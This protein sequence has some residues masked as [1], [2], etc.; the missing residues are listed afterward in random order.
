MED[1]VVITTSDAGVLHASRALLLCNS[2][3]FAD[4]LVALPDNDADPE[5]EDEGE[6]AEEEGQ[7]PHFNVPETHGVFKAFLAVMSGEEEKRK[8][9]LGQLVRDEEWEQLAQAAASYNVDCVRVVVQSKIWELTATHQRALSAFTMAT[10]LKD[11]Q[12][13]NATASAALIA[14]LAGGRCGASKAWQDKLHEWRNR[15][16]AHASTTAHSQPPP[17]FGMLGQY[18]FP[19]GPCQPSTYLHVWTE[20]TRFAINVF[21]QAPCFERCVA[22]VAS[23]NGLCFAHKTFIKDAAVALDAAHARTAPLLV[24]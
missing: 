7:A 17:P 23:Q 13:I 21:Q 2:P 22:D 11:N 18:C 3:V 20:G 24:I 6:D 8:G 1:L 16:K 19:Y 9:A 10:T 14:L 15:L 12:L 5:E 4:M